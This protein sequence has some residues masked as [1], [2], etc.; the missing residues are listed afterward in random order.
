MT[1]KY[2][3]N[4]KNIESLD[5]IIIHQGG[6]EMII[7][8]EDKSKINQIY[9]KLKPLLSHNGFNDYFKPIKRLGKGAFATVYLI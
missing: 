4:E 8:C 6:D 5:K 2:D 3:M 9:A 1:P 7:E